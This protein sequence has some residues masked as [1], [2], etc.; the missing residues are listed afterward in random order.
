M[1][2]KLTYE[3][4]LIM[5]WGTNKNKN[6]YPRQRIKFPKEL[7]VTV[8]FNESNVIG[9]ATN[10][11]TTKKG[12]VCN[13]V[14]DKKISDTLI[15]ILAGSQV[16]EKGN[17]NVIRHLELLGLSSAFNHVNKECNDNL[18]KSGGIKNARRKS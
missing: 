2:G 9:K 13:V 1:T 3:D 8:D 7:V 6:T 12:V 5:V 11:R 17:K 18:K 16:L 14:L 15:P 4:V 10:F